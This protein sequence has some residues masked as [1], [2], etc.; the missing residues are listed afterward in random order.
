MMFHQNRIGRPTSSAGLLGAGGPTTRAMTEPRQDADDAG[1]ALRTAQP[2]APAAPHRGR[3]AQS[4][5]A[6]GPGQ[7]RR[8]H[9]DPKEL[10]LVLGLAAVLYLDAA[11]AGENRIG[12]ESVP[13]VALEVVPLLWRSRA[14]GRVLLVV[15]AASFGCLVTLDPHN[16]VVL[17]TMV[18]V[19]AFTKQT[20]RRRAVGAGLL[21][22][23]VAAVAVVVFAGSEGDARVIVAL[24]CLL[25]AVAAATGDAARARSAF[26]E[27]VREREREREHE[28]EARSQRL[29]AEERLRIAREVH[30]VVAHA[31]M[32]IN[33]QAG[34]A[35]HLAARDPGQAQAALRDIKRSSGGALRDLRGALGVLR[36]GTE[37]SMS[38]TDGL[39]TL[40][41]LVAT[42]RAAGI[43][44]ALQVEGP[45]DTVPS[46]VGATIFRIVQEAT[47]N[48]VRHAGAQHATVRIAIGRS[49]V[50]VVVED[51]GADETAAATHRDGS[52]NG[53]RGMAERAAL[54]GGTLEAGGV[55]GGW[56]VHAT[57]PLR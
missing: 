42:L 23:L 11:L 14:P 47:T 25:V 5:L 18:A 21:G 24:N 22:V 31:I 9:V 10:L 51:G 29:V 43:D 4:V 40:P 19:Y 30:D 33:I 34:T 44:C 39:G 38:P 53:L 46:A 6:G 55:E 2:P 35:A 32:A 13:V 27:S 20:D 37:T 7:R 26:R 36:D 3:G 8:T 45:P 56:R 49:E 15:L 12:P 1:Q 50:D 41:R 17:P 28:M 54:V 52:G 48:I 16:T 57:L